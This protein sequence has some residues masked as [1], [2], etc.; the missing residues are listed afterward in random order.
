[1]ERDE[2]VKRLTVVLEDE[3]EGEKMSLGPEKKVVGEGTCE[4]FK[5]EELD[6]VL[7]KYKEVM[8]S[9]PG[10]MDRIQ[11]SIDTGHGANTSTPIQASRCFVRTNEGRSGC[12][13][14][15]RYN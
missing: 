13:C 7:G 1:M 15:S 14:G 2:L 9:E 3:R 4:D 12:A 5:Q 11:I 6:V 8:T 10:L